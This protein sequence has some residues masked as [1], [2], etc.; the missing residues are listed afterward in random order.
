MRKYIHFAKCL[1]PKLSEA[2]CEV[3]SNEYSRLRSQDLVESDLARTQPV[4]PRT[5]ETLIRLSTAHA[6]ARLARIV[7]VVDAH[8]AIELVQFAY[9][10]KVLEKEKRKRRRSVDSEDDED[11]N[12]NEKENEPLNNGSTRKTK[13]TRIV[14]SQ[15]DSDDEPIE[16]VIDSGDLTRRTT[17][18]TTTATTSSQQT[19]TPQSTEEMTVDEIIS[20]QRLSVFQFK[21]QAAFR[22]AREQS[23]SLERLTNYINQENAEPFSQDEI[24]SAIVQM[25]ELNQIMLADNIVF[26]I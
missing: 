25:T 8:A 11:A 3:I 20:A 21:L 6:K 14:Q 1:K 4:T 5:L 13:R 16:E 7:A 19:E 23:M 10:K 26:L 17:R 9:F 22:Q 24:N 15:D 12:E 18:T 2:A